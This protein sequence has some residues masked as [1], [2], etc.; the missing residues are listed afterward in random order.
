MLLDIQ[1]CPV[2][3]RQVE[4]ARI[5]VVHKVLYAEAVKRVVEEDGPSARD[6]KRLPVTRPR[7]IESDRNT[8][9]F[10]KVGFL[11][12]IAMIINCTAEMESKSQKIQ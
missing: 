12:F 1:K 5:R 7:P 11:A 3:E 4:V 8:M 10:S 2:R 6:P 9:C